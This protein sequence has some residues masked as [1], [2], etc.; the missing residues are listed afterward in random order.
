MIGV[1]DLGTH[2]GGAGNGVDAGVDVGD[3]ALEHPVGEGFA[4]GGDFLAGGE[5]SEEGF[6]YGKV[7]F[8]GVDEIEGGEDFAGG[9]ESSDADLAEAEDAA[10]RSDDGAVGDFRLGFFDLLEREVPGGEV[11]LKADPGDGAVVRRG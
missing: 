4:A 7:E 1:G 10:K 11:F 9:N 3:D 8:D 6:G 5:A 2:D